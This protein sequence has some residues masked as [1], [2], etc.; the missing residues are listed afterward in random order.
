MNTSMPAQYTC[1]GNQASPPLTIIGAPDG[2]KTFALVMEDSDVPKQL[3]PES[4]FLH[5]IVFN[6]PG[7]I[8]EIT[9]NAHVGIVGANSLGK[10]TYVGPNS[11]PQFE[12]RQHRYVFTL[13]A[14][15]K[16]LPLKA[17]ASKDKLVAAMRGHVIA[18]TRLVGLYQR[19]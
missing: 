2:T 9:E 19:T 1:D 7:S 14:L 12:P 10:K 16:E 17:G 13:Y 3:R 5:W 8:S 11:P 15:D 6:I 4:A 18:R